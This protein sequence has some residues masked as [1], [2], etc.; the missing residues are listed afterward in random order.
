MLGMSAASAQKLP[1]V[2]I[3]HL[4]ARWDVR[5]VPDENS[6]VSDSRAKY[7]LSPFGLL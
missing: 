4:S 6:P 5:F 2:D 3:G 1:D 7:H